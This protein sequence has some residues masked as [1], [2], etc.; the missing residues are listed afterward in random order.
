MEHPASTIRRRFQL[1]DQGNDRVVTD[2]NQRLACS[3]AL[4]GIIAGE[5]IDELLDIA[6]N[7]KLELGVH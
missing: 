5:L 3:L 7:R 6:A 1:V 2:L 4:R